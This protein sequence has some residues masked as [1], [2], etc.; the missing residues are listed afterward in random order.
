MKFSS[1]LLFLLTAFLYSYTGC[2]SSSGVC[3]SSPDNLVRGPYL[4][5]NPANSD[6]VIVKWR[7]STNEIGIL[8]VNAGQSSGTVSNHFVQMVP[9]LEENTCAAVASTDRHWYYAAD[10]TYNQQAIIS[11]PASAEEV[12]YKLTFSSGCYRDTIKNANYRPEVHLMVSG[13]CGT[14]RCSDISCSG[15]FFDRLLDL[16]SYESPDISTPGRYDGM[17]FLG[18]QSYGSSQKY[19]D[20]PA[21]ILTRLETVI[22]DNPNTPEDETLCADPSVAD[23]GLDY[24]LQRNFFNVLKD[25]MGQSWMILTMGNHDSDYR[26]KLEKEVYGDSDGDPST[27]EIIDTIPEKWNVEDYFEAFEAGDRD[28]GYYSVKVGDVLFISLNSEIRKNAFNIY[29]SN[30]QDRLSDMLIWFQGELDRDAKWKVVSMHHPIHSGGPRR[31]RNTFCPQYDYNDVCDPDEF[32]G[33]NFVEE[34]T[35]IDAIGDMIG[36]EGND[37]DLV[38]YGHNHIYERS[39]LVDGHYSFIQ[40][41]VNQDPQERIVVLDDKDTPQ[42]EGP[43]DLISDGCNGCYDDYLAA[44]SANNLASFDYNRFNHASYTK[45][46]SRGTVYV[47]SGNAGKLESIDKDRN[48]DDVDDSFSAGQNF[49]DHPIMRPFRSPVTKDNY[50]DTPPT[51]YEQLEDGGR[52]LNLLGAGHLTIKGNTLTYRHIGRSSE[53]GLEPKVLD[54][55]SINKYDATVVT[56]C[57]EDIEF[58]INTLVPAGAFNAQWAT[59]NDLTNS[60]SVNAPVNVD[61]LIGE[62]WRWTGFVN[63][64]LIR[65]YYYFESGNCAGKQSLNTA[66]AALE[67]ESD[68]LLEKLY[69]NPAQDLLN[70]HFNQSI[71]D[72]ESIQIFNLQ[73][74][75]IKEWKEIS[76][77][78]EQT[79]QLDVSS[80]KTGQYFLS[81]QLNGSSLR[82]SFIKK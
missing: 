74:A 12:A 37:V 25:W 31:G 19:E 22:V 5:L 9:V 39:F 61:D 24:S 11:L 2:G 82:T 70:L 67:D 68:F 43:M 28:K 8:T 63:G 30:Y 78:N 27:Q 16:H 77:I 26:W 13:D 76:V 54:A 48:N 29:G 51:N 4:Q 18:D 44:A 46:D 42:I 10:T 52:G 56:I 60:F 81:A 47:M 71:N 75:L 38:L 14:D 34:E 80:L 45:I 65:N 7:S 62:T 79:I 49:F 40:H 15:S 17:L 23:D 36:A 21:E 66:Q 59:V 1:V 3:N 32:C 72:F 73:G 69:P 53:N 33:W 35:V 55:F 6:E 20:V 57:E 64:E 58:D 41:A 50:D